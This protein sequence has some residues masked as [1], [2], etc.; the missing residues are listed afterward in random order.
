MMWLDSLFLRFGKL[1]LLPGRMKKPAA[2]AAVLAVLVHM[3]AHGAV[4]LE[5]S[6]GKSVMSETDPAMK[7]LG[8]GDASTP[9]GKAIAMYVEGEHAKAIELAAPLA[10]KGDAAALYLMGFAHESGQGAEAS[11]EKAI[12]SYRKAAAKNHSDA[13]YRLANLLI[14]SGQSDRVQEGREILEKKAAI[15]PTVAGRMLG[16]AFLTG[17]LTP[18]PAPETAV[19]WWKK[20]AEADDVPSMFL[21]ARFYDGQLGHPEMSDAK[22]AYS[23]FLKAAEKGDSAAM[24]AVGSRLLN[25]KAITRDEQKG[26][27]WLNKAIAAKEYSGYLALGDYQENEKKKPEE[28]LAYYESGAAEGQPDCMLRAADFYINGKGVKKDVEKGVGFLEKAAE[29]GAAQAHLMLAARIMEEEKPDIG[30]AYAHLLSAANSG[31]PLA[32]NE[33]GLFYLSGKMGVA[34]LSAAV[35]WFGRAAQAGLAAAQNNLATLHERGAGVPQNYEDAAKLYALAAQQ[36]NAGAT[37]ALARF[38]AAGAATQVD[39]VRAWVLA[40]LAAERG[41]KENSAAFLKE[42][43]KVM[44]KEQI[45]EA[46]KGFAEIMAEK[47]AEK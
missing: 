21:L 8:K 12:E 46:K 40:S 6:D 45:A 41:E 43:E 29:A 10:E 4:S 22:L 38:H 5:A 7:S 2:A 35:S 42:L 31:M 20:A 23:Y 18:E 27:M 3:T 47:P 44:T 9:A 36:G 39:T 28:A 37:L 32:Q 17:R 34:D 19:S 1:R 25:S 26:S 30:K 13:T 16:E 24:V 14:S 15:D 11:R 33:L